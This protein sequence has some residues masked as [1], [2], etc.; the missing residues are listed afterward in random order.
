MAMDKPS[1]SSSSFSGVGGRSSR[2]LGSVSLDCFAASL[3]SG[4]VMLLLKIHYYD[5][6]HRIASSSSYSHCYHQRSLQIQTQIS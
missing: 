3:K 2:S 5:Y 6:L 1:S 4:T